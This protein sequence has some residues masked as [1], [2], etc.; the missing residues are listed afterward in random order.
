VITRIAETA[1]AANETG[2][3]GPSGIWDY[4]VVAVAVIAVAVALFLAAK[5]L[6]APGEESPDHIKRKILDE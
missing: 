1:F 5:Y 2:T 3:T 4:F 6:I